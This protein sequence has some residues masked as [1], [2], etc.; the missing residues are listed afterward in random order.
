MEKNLR[1]FTDSLDYKHRKLSTIRQYRDNVNA[2]NDWLQNRNKTI[3]TAD[4]G[5]LRD[6]AQIKKNK[7]LY[8][9]VLE[10]F[11]FYNLQNQEK[12]IS[13]IIKE[14]P[15]QVKESQAIVIRWWQFKDYV[16]EIE[17]NHKNKQ[18]LA[19]L[20]LLWS[21]IK[22]K[23]IIN[24]RKLNIDFQT[25]TIHLNNNDYYITSDAWAALEKFVRPEERGKNE[26]L[27]KGIKSMRYAHSLIKQ[28]LGD[29]K[30]LA[31][32]IR[33]G[34]ERELKTKGRATM[35][36]TPES[37]KALIE[38]KQIKEEKT[39]FIVSDEP[40]DCIVHQIFEFGK[41]INWRI[42]M[43]KEEG[44]LQRLLEGYLNAVLPEPII[45]EYAFEGYKEN[46]R[47]D[48][49][50]GKEQIPLE[51]K[52]CGNKPIGDYIRE[53]SS[54]VKEFIRFH[55]SSK[56]ILVVGDT[57]RILKNKKHN[58]LHDNIQIIVI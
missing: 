5:D 41:K 20:N 17:K 21:E 7:T 19:F 52:L 9:S 34:C 32:E 45:P 49:T 37:N 11:K 18:H 23:D 10:Y 13:Q 29:H 8:Y 55:N 36:V 56:G 42:G 4:E 16:S 3:E 30:L 53:G 47:I 25:Q 38:K 54:Q 6:W 12:I 44:E 31:K 33:N 27:F 28:Y 58:G 26:L 48:F 35:F 1:R 57:H 24:L 46:S 2:L 15:K 51:V 22:L 50:I 43:I 39:N 40:F 14:A